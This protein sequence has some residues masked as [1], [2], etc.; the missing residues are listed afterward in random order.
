M[1][2]NNRGLRLTGKYIESSIDCLRDP[3]IVAEN[4]VYYA[5][6]TGW[7]YYRNS[8]GSLSDGWEGPVP[9]VE[10]P[11]DAQ[12][13]FWAPE[14]HRYGGAYY[15]FTTYRSKTT[16]HRGC[17]IAES[18]TPEGPFRMITGGH[19]TP[20]DWDCI[21]GTL[22]IDRAGQPWM[23]FV[24]EWTSMPDH[25][26]TMEAAKLSPDLTRFISEPITLFR[27]DE[28]EWAVRGVTDGCFMYRTADGRLLMTWSNLDRY[29]YCAAVAES[30]NG[31]I[32]G[33]WFHHKDLLYTKGEDRPYDGG[34]GMIFTALDGKKYFSMHSPNGRIGDRREKP[35]FY[36]IEECI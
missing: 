2:T 28:P 31:E 8:S 26:G 22:Y 25:V 14:V 36:E 23:V 32:D 19:I 15:M 17:F 9:C 27:A 12:T 21:D 11:E 3:F 7:V 18:E 24:H 1:M 34:H 6:G 16:G 13:D 10:I 5:Y 35:V 33:K 29:G 20:K 30:D 4:G